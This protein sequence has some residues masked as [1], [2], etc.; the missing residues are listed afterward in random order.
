MPKMEKYDIYTYTYSIDPKIEEKKTDEIP[1]TEWMNN[2]SA[3][4]ILMYFISI[5]Q[6]LINSKSSQLSAL[7]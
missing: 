4:N 6:A 3:P 1:T 2:G 5:T 7:S